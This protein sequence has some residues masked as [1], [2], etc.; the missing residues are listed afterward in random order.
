M[1][2]GSPFNAFNFKHSP[3][4]ANEVVESIGKLPESLLKKGVMID[5]TLGGG[6]HSAL[7]L[8][9]YPSINII[10]IDQDPHAREAASKR[11]EHYGSRVE[12]INSNFADFTPNENVLIVFADLGVSVIN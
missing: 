7:I 12:I 5:A 4:L 6:G 1:Q 3:V 8:E 2:D 11:L 10:G 9:T